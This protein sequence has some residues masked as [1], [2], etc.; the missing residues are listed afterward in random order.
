[1]NPIQFSKLVY[2]V[3]CGEKQMKSKVFGV[4]RGTSRQMRRAG[5]DQSQEAI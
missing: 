2:A 5:P 4:P 3:H 1:M